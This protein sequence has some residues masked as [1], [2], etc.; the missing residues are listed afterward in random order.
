MSDIVEH[1]REEFSAVFD[2]LNVDVEDDNIEDAY[3]IDVQHWVDTDD[4]F[5]VDEDKEKET[6]NDDFHLARE[7]L[8]K[9]LDKSEKVLDESFNQIAVKTTPVMLQLGQEAIKNIQ[10]GVKALTD[11]HNAYQTVKQKELK[12]KKEENPEEGG[13]GK[14][15]DKYTDKNGNKV[16]FDD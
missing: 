6:F 8:L 3:A 2:S 11:L 5:K 7:L 1:V 4:K 12:N 16:G 9:S 13:E 14:E 10:N 15:A